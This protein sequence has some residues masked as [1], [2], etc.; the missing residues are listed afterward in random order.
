MVA[1]SSWTSHASTVSSISSN[2]A[3]P[4]PTI[5]SKP[6]SWPSNP[7]SLVYQPKAIIA[8]KQKHPFDWTS[9]ISS[10]QSSPASSVMSVNDREVELVMK[11]SYLSPNSGLTPS[12]SPLL[13]DI[14]DTGASQPSNDI[15]DID[16]YIES[17]SFLEEMTRPPEVAQSLSTDNK[18]T[19]PIVSESAPTYTDLLP[20]TKTSDRESLLVQVLKTKSSAKLGK[21]RSETTGL[22]DNASKQLRPSDPIKEITTLD[23]SPP[24]QS[25]AS[26]TIPELTPVLPNNEPLPK[27]TQ[28]RLRKPRAKKPVVSCPASSSDESS[29]STGTT[30]HPLVSKP[31][32]D[33]NLNADG[34]PVF[35][36][37]PITPSPLTSPK[38]TPAKRTSN[39]PNSSRKRKAA[40]NNTSESAVKPKADINKKKTKPDPFCIESLVERFVLAA[41]NKKLPA[42]PKAP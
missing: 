14:L 37:H 5:T 12:P 42:D 40:T 31:Q 7:S 34:T 10:A 23:G 13:S 39:T 1:V 16:S 20:V 29:T 6:F 24:R 25:K 18:D 35:I 22:G 28:I 15:Q 33:V 17:F 30:P 32:V 19:Q 8:Q 9:P 11:K 3:T 27:Q 38:P 4:P 36:I 26:T 2:I 41:K 21:R